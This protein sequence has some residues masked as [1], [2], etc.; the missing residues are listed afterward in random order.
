MDWEKVEG[1][2]WG[3]IAR[4]DPMYRPAIAAI[5]RGRT[6]ASSMGAAGR[7]RRFFVFLAD[8][9][10][11]PIDATCDDIDDYVS[12]SGPTIRRTPSATCLRSR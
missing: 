8:R 3:T 7:L 5:R 12:P 1:R 6:M 9:G 11:A 10:V 2:L 4:T